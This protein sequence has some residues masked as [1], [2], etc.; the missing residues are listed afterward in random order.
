MLHTP[1]LYKVM[2]VLCQVHDRASSSDLAHQTLGA[3][4]GLPR[5][6][7]QLA[8][9]G[10]DF[11]VEY[12]QAIAKVNEQLQ[13]GTFR[14]VRGGKKV[15]SDFMPATDFYIAEDYH[16][17]YLSK[18]GRFNRPQDASKGATTPIRCYG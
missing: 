4:P 12:V 13:N 10:V 11:R 7:T 2:G 8:V 16:Q 6:D 1:D 17:Q 9:R 14:R 5:P 15:V 3:R 18:G